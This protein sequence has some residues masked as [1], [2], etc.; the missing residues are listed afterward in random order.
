MTLNVLS[1]SESIDIVLVNY[2]DEIVRS[3]NVKLVKNRLR[4]DL[5]IGSYYWR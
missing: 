3:A 5:F 2:D 4:E 1:I